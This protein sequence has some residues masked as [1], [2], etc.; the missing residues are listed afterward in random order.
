MRIAQLSDVY[1]PRLGGIEAHVH[2]VAI[3]QA[4]L[5]HT[6]DVLTTTSERAEQP[7]GPGSDD[8]VEPGVRVRRLH[9]ATSSVSGLRDYDVV[10]AHVSTMSPFAARVAAHAAMIGVPTVV[11]VHSLWEAIDPLPRLMVLTSGLRRAPVV[12]TAVSAVAARLVGS[13][14]P[15]GQHA[16]VLP[17]AVDPRLWRHA[18]GPRP[19][20]GTLHVVSAMRF[21]VRK[22]PVPLLRIMRSVQDSLDAPVLRLTLVGEGSQRAAVERHVDRH[23]M[24][25]WVQLTGRMD[26]AGVAGVLAGAD[27]YISPGR[28]E[29]F[30]L[31]PLEARCAGLPVVGRSDS[32]LAEFIDHGREGLIATSDAEMARHLRMLA[33]SPE[34]RESIAAHNR[35]TTTDLTW[36]AF[37]ERAEA[38]YQVAGERAAARR[39]AARAPRRLIR[40]R[41]DSVESNR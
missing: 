1:L 19:A 22:R 41:A 35:A 34:L 21:A 12:W 30:G 7:P 13:T 39:S 25:S 40:L 29:S 24:R 4:A 20:D 16:H 17:N 37:L 31:A 28:K 11:T 26:R 23:G 27:V 14:L 5:G 10:H 15:V 8:P 32:G 2:D 33:T 9:P 6:V 38:I 3:R 18:I 36:D